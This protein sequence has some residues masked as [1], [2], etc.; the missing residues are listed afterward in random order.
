MSHILKTQLKTAKE[1]ND[2]LNP[3]SSW[4]ARNRANLMAQIGNTVSGDQPRFRFDYVWQA[5]N[6]FVPGRLA[7]TVVRPMAVFVLVG[8]VATSGWIASVGATQNCLPG[9][10]CY[11]VKLAAEKTQELVTTVTGAKDQ[12]AQMHLEFATRRANE[13]KKVVENVEKTRRHA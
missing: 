11:G 13:V 7:Y 4:V 12:Q 6:I 2:R 8:A 1:L 5:I 10:I 3:D 9:E